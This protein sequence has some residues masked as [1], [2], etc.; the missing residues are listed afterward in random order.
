VLTDSAHLVREKFLRS[1]A[2][3]TGFQLTLPSLPNGYVPD[4]V[5]LNLWDRSCF[6]GDAKASETPGNC[7]T[8]VRLTRYLSWLHQY[9]YENS[10]R[11][12]FAICHGKPAQVVLWQAAVSEILGES[13][14]YSNNV[15][16]RSFAPD[17]QLLWYVHSFKLMR[18][19]VA[20]SEPLRRCR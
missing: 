3:M 16:H 5:Q 13:G 14:F 7:Q 12:V 17:I 2:V 20:I 10:T 4:V 1:L 15:E 9:G 11:V 18:K 19:P 8:R 6:I